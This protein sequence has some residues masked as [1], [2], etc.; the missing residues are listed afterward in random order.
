MSFVIL[1]WKISLKKQYD[2]CKHYTAYLFLDEFSAKVCIC[3]RMEL[4]LLPKPF[5][6]AFCSPPTGTFPSRDPA[7]K[8]NS[9]W[10]YVLN[11]SDLFIS[12]WDVRIG[13]KRKTW[14]GVVARVIDDS[15][16]S[17]NS[18]TNYRFFLRLA[19]ETFYRDILSD[20]LY[21]CKLTQSLILL[22]IGKP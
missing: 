2:I 4:S 13:M 8:L 19:T 10:R 3:Y 12:W 11:A 18:I 22:R 9:D 20:R 5:L 7:R 21:V 15:R 16:K 17:M 6:L 1:N 14:Q